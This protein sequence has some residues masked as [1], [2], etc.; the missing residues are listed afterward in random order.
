MAP[1]GLDSISPMYN[2][3]G[4][5]KGLQGMASGKFNADLAKKPKTSNGMAT[6][7]VVLMQ[8]ISDLRTTTEP[9]SRNR[10]RN[11]TTTTAPRTKTKRRPTQS[12]QQWPVDQAVDAK[13]RQTVRV[14]S[15]A[16]A[17]IYVSTMT[18]SKQPKQSAAAQEVVQ[19]SQPSF[20]AA[21]DAAGTF[22]AQRISYSSKQRRRLLRP[23][24]QCG[25]KL[26]AIKENDGNASPKLSSNSRQGVNHTSF[27]G[28]GRH[29]W[30]P[31]PRTLTSAELAD[32]KPSKKNPASFLERR[33]YTTK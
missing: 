5:N 27:T 1:K 14:T 28:T 33:W 24:M 4:R 13:M 15:S 22:L 32:G 26:S 12:V 9:S 3:R 11:P 30:S 2:I 16:T 25:T 6:N 21:Q 7:D 18:S 23:S 20:S 17:K 31:V 10:S 29:S 19:P 8:L